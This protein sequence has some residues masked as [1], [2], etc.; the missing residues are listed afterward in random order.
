MPKSKKEYL[1]EPINVELEWIKDIR[2]KDIRSRMKALDL[3]ISITYTYF[4]YHD[5]SVTQLA[6]INGTTEHQ[7][8]IW[9]LIG[10]Y[11]LN[12]GKHDFGSGRRL[13]GNEWDILLRRYPEAEETLPCHRCVWADLRTGR[14]ICFRNCKGFNCFQS[15]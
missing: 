12:G 10:A 5:Y 1:S 9:I 11:T 3:S 14:V 6:K 4:V 7:I 2:N 13:Q 8:V 15:K